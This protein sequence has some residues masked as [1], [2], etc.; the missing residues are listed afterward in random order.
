MEV[1]PLLPYFDRYIIPSIFVDGL[2]VV[3]VT[4]HVVQIWPKQEFLYKSGGG[5]EVMN[6]FHPFS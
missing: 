4:S 1:L 6:V 2:G 5:K 3:G